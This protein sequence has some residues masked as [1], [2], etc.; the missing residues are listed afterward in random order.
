MLGLAVSFGKGG[1]PLA[2]V[3][4]GVIAL[5]TAYSYAGLS[6]DYPSE[7]GTVTFLNTAFG[8][9]VLSGGTN[10][11]LRVSYIIM[12]SLYSSAFG[13]YAANLFPHDWDIPLLSHLF[14][15]VSS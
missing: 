9:G 13:S 14:L 15:S 3:F 1:T 7:G 12:L 5:L 10:N 8:K 6:R 2:F 11:L 4:A